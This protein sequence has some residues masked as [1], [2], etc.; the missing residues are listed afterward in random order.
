MAGY[1][2]MGIYV[3]DKELIKKSNNSILAIISV[4][5]GLLIYIIRFK[6]KE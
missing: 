5:L 1:I 6:D 2:A 4:P 3:K